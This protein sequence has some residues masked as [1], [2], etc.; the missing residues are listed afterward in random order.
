MFWLL[1]SDVLIEELVFLLSCL[2]D[3]NILMPIDEI[4][5]KNPHEKSLVNIG[6]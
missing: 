2:F 4:N 6:M 1:Y 5:L 3:Y